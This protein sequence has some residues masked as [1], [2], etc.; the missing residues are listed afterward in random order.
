MLLNN[1]HGSFMVIAKSMPRFHHQVTQLGV[2][3]KN[4]LYGPLV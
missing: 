1:W 2:D 3:P 4:L